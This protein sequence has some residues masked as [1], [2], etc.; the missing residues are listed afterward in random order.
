M[1]GQALSSGVNI[2]MSS[3]MCHP[4]AVSSLILFIFHETKWHE[5]GSLKTGLFVNLKVCDLDIMKKDFD[6]GI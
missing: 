1:S 2:S 3:C 5:C 6:C 4:V